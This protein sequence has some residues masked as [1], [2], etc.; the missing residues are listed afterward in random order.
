MKFADLHLHTLYSDG[1]STPE[2][3]VQG[4][5][6]AGLSAIAIADHDTVRAIAPALEE[7]K[8]ESLE[9]IPAIELSAEVDSL[10]V[11]ILGYYLDYESR[12]LL[13]TLDFL[14]AN[15]IARI[16]AMVKKL[17]SLGLDVTAKQV[18]DTAGKGIVGRLHLA[19]TLAQ[20]G[21][22]K[23]VFEAFEKYIGDRGPGYVCGF[24][25]SPS[26][27]IRLIREAGGVAVLAHPCLLKRD[28]LIPLFVEYGLQGLEAWY[29]EQNRV[30]TN[31]YL[32]L[33]K[34]YNLVATGGSD[35][36]GGGKPDVKL[37]SAKVPYEAVENLK[38]LLQ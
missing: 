27:A 24:R 6:K 1:T 12:K 25:F 11:H 2:E 14:R 21:L 29:P 38:K 16:H 18:F 5:K 28:E 32:A 17:N 33:A 34:Q 26:E 31:F 22:V 9:F 4:A 23:S 8:N 35:F 20:R 30:T 7:A 10:E 13:K 3:V 37:G 36:H 15:R 19:R